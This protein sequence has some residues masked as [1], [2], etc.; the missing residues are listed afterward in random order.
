M[1]E[2]VPKV[3]FGRG[4]SVGHG[5]SIG[6]FDTDLPAGSG[7]AAGRV[8]DL[9]DRERLG[10]ALERVDEVLYAVSIH[11]ILRVAEM[12]QAQTLWPAATS[13]IVVSTMNLSSVRAGTIS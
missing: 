5:K 12:V 3:P 1:V 11:E 2:S 4:E 6:L 13:K 10:L 8:E 9:L 7:E